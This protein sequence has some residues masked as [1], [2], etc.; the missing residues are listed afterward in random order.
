MKQ[1]IYEYE[2]K[3]GE[4]VVPT[5]IEIS[6]V[7]GLQA[8]LNGKAPT[9]HT[10]I[11]SNVTGLQSALDGKSNVG[12]TH[13][14]DDISDFDDAVEDIVAALDITSAV[15]GTIITHPV[16]PSA[17]WF[18]CRGQ[19]LGQG[20]YPAL[21]SVLGSLHP[22][23]VFR[24]NNIGGTSSATT[25]F[26]LPDNSGLVSSSSATRIFRSPNCLAGTAFAAANITAVS[27]L[28]APNFYARSEIT[29]T[30]I[31][32][33]SGGS[34]A[35]V[36]STDGGATWI[37]PTTNHGQQQGLKIFWFDNGTTYGKFIAFTRRVSGSLPCTVY[38]DD[39]GVT[40][41]EGTAF[42]GASQY[43]GIRD[44]AI[45]PT[46]EMI[47]YTEGSGSGRLEVWWR[48]TDLGAT[49]TQGGTLPLYP[50]RSG[51]GKAH[52]LDYSNGYFTLT[53]RMVNGWN[54]DTGTPGPGFYPG[55]RVL[56]EGGSEWWAPLL[57]TDF[58]GE[59]ANNT[60][61]ASGLVPNWLPLKGRL[62]IFGQRGIISMLG[63]GSHTSVIYNW[64]TSASITNWFFSQC[65]GNADGYFLAL[66]G[67][68]PVFARLWT[69]FNQAGAGNFYLP[70]ETQSYARRWIKVQ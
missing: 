39:D 49:W 67:T 4:G 27:G 63:D 7:N 35:Y 32:S 50:D 17:D 68:T 40:W 28:N 54:P 51:G 56:E 3:G 21:F 52:N 58:Q 65:S 30:I 44:G 6:D 38:S 55:L 14:S 24:T 61:A 13:T 12:H 22:Q 36:R 23:P 45:S 31:G 20:D 41:V 1:N 57:P 16:Q 66:N 26:L 60:A 70:N 9:A 29:G 43:H 48:S 62:Y 25:T 47:C 19:I 18:E 5:D 64:A 59:F 11:I 34:H 33:C 15:I 46:G 2:E 42:P 8:A 69:D 10:H 53:C 37:Q